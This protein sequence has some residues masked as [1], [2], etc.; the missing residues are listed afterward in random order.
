MAVLNLDGFLVTA[1]DVYRH[2]VSLAV[3]MR[4]AEVL[5]Q[6]IVVP[7][8]DVKVLEAGSGQDE[9]L[10]DVPFFVA[11]ELTVLAHNYR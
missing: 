6:K 1:V 3:L 9:Q 4:D 5:G 8:V 11:A 2:V 10:P 7:L